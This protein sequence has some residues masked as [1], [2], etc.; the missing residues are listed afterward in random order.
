MT[1]EELKK[2]IESVDYRIFLV[3]MVDH[4]T[5]KDRDLLHSLERELRELN[6]K[7]EKGDYEK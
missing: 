5:S 6:E 1:K 2:E 7:L 4:W 3:H